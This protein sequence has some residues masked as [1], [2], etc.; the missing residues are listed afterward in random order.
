MSNYVCVGATIKLLSTKANTNPYTKSVF[1]TTNSIPAIIWLKRDGPTNCFVRVLCLV[2]VASTTTQ[3]T[4]T[5][6][7]T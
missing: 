6:A 5:T 4:T 7:T 1:Q 2:R 3:T